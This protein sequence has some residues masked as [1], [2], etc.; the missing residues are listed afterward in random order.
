[1]EYTQV[2]N[3]LH[4]LHIGRASCTPHARLSV[5][6]VAHPRTHAIG[7][8]QTKSSQLSLWVT[9]I[10]EVENF[11]LESPTAQTRPTSSCLLYWW[12]PLS[13][14]PPRVCALREMEVNPAAEGWLGCGMAWE[15]KSGLEVPISF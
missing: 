4:V 8:T 3:G 5:T 11:V 9:P 12:K 13:Q 1:M 14:W 15:S 6:L 2:V 10:G 7:L